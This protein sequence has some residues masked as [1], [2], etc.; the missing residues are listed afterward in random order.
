MAKTSK[1]AAKGTVSIQ[2]DRGWL[3]LQW[4]YRRKRYRLSLGLPS[5]RPGWAIAQARA[6]KIEQDMRLEVFDETLNR[7]RGSEPIEKKGLSVVKLFEQ[8][9]AFKQQNLDSRT[10]E[11]YNG[12][13]GHLKSQLSAM[14]VHELTEDLAFQFRDTL[15][16]TLAPITVR[17]RLAMLR[18]AWYWAIDR[19]IVSSNP[20]KN[21]K[22][23]VPP[24]ARP[25]PFT[26]D[27][28]SRIIEGFRNDKD[29]CHYADVVE[30]VLHLGCRPGEAF[31]L[32]W[33]H[34]NKDCSV[35]WIGES[36]SRGQQKP[37]KTNRERQFTLTS[38]IQNLLLKR[39][40]ERPEPD[41][42]VFPSKQGKPIDDHN[43]RNR[44]WKTILSRANVP[45][46]KPY[47]TRHTFISHAISQGA[48]PSQVSELVGNSEETIYRNYLGGI[49]GQVKLIE[50][51]EDEDD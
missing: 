1:R 35:I 31:G 37:T 41:T 6:L 20:W 42:L 33:K 50:L 15:I 24:K 10:I 47:N 45:Y 36:W 32:K 43:F 13:T 49:D 40:P 3:R 2:D 34:L 8:Y 5:D 51:W 22:V 46:R 14:T 39:R 17:E 29:Y 23:K 26:A 44:A 25:K 38:R 18:S 11:K 12:L 27:E 21:V 4:T 19:D 48:T 28:I 30:F 9:V 16:K 7:Y